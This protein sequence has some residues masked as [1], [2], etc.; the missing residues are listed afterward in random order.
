MDKEF[1]ALL[2]H[3]DHEHRL[4]GK[5]IVGLRTNLEGEKGSKI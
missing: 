5:V 3:V 2:E 4:L 1:K